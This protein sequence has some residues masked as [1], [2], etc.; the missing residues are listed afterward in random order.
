MIQFKIKAF[1]LRFD[2]RIGNTHNA[3]FLLALIDRL[4]QAADE[5]NFCFS[6]IKRNGQYSVQ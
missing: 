3:D 5:N 6:E 2:P 1:N 4:K